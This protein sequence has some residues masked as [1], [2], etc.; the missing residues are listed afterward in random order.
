MRV[1]LQHSIR[2]ACCPLPD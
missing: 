2:A 1:R